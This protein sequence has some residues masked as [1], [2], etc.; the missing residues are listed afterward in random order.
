VRKGYSR[1]VAYALL[2]PD[3]PTARCGRKRVGGRIGLRPCRVCVR[4]R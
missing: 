2:R 4:R 3:D 1:S